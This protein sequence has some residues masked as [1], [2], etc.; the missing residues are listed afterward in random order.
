MADKKN[1]LEVKNYSLSFSRYEKGLKLK[2]LQVI[3]DLSI[4]VQEG[5]MVAIVGASGSGKSLL[6]HGILG[7]L[8]RNAHMSGEIIYDGSPLT[9]DRIKRIRGKEIVLIPQNVTALDPLMKVG[10]QIRKGDKSSE[11]RQATMQML[12]R[13]GLEERTE[14][15]YPFELSGG[16]ARRILIATA[17]MEHPKLVI[18]DEPTP[19]L[20]MDVAKRVLGHFRELAD[21]GAG[22]LLIAH[23]LELAAAV[24]DR[25]AVFYAGTVLEN[26]QAEAFRTGEGLMHPYSKALFDAMPQ[27]GTIQSEVD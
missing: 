23:D 20:H 3:S 6:A 7:I 21:E 9:A 16:M 15:L 10:P 22:V 17:A 13:Y 26:V 2:E 19:G 11:A 4:S 14:N 24:A 27:H 18:A 25:V 5:E 8:P 12:R 1:V